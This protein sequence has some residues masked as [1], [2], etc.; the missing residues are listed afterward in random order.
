MLVYP[1][2]KIFGGALEPPSTPISAKATGL[3]TVLENEYH[4]PT[5]E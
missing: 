2:Q 3:N 1:I 4:T 5:S